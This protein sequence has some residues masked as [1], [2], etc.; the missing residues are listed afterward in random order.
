MLSIYNMDVKKEAGIFCQFFQKLPKSKP[1]FLVHINEGPG[2]RSIW[3]F[4]ADIG[5][6]IALSHKTLHS[7]LVYQKSGREKAGSTAIVVKSKLNSNVLSGISPMTALASRR[8]IQS[9]VTSVLYYQA[10]PSFPQCGLHLEL[11]YL[12]YNPKFSLWCREHFTFRN[13][14]CESL[15][16]PRQKEE[17][18]HLSQCFSHADSYTSSKGQV[19]W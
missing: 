4:V 8:L 13:S 12:K 6:A 18:L 9:K 14:E 3:A 11:W 16:A 2:L 15:Q 5:F 17:K 10:L 7:R 1:Y 19:A